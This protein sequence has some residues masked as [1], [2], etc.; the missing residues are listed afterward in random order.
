GGGPPRGNRRSSSPAN[1]SALPG[2]ASRV[3]DLAPR[4]PRKPGER[5]GEMRD[6]EREEVL[7]SLKEK[8]PERYRDLLEQYHRALAEGKRVGG[9]EE[10]AD[11][12]ED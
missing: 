3:G 1:R 8:L 9:G 2:G 5:W 12:E 11:G 10:G 7:Q 4:P 6:K